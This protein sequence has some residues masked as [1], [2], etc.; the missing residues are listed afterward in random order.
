M[1]CIRPIHPPIVV[2]QPFGPTSYSGEPAFGYWM[3]FHQ[4]TDYACPIGTAVLAMAPGK[5]VIGHDDEW[6]YGTHILIDHLNGFRT[7]YGH[8]SK[9][10]VSDGQSVA[11][12]Q[13]IALSG[14]TGNSTGPHLHAGLLMADDYP[15]PLQVVLFD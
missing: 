4:G 3:H 1:R 7:L 15:L 12:G 5:V 6:G 9:S 13:E 11:M 2:S 14:N 8:L 10:L